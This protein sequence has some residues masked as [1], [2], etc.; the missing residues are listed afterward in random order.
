MT[1]NF[2]T[3]PVVDVHKENIKTI[4]PSLMLALK[5]ATYVAIDTELSGI[6]DR[7]MLNAKQI[8]D[9][10]KSMAESAKSRSI[11][12]MGLS[13]FKLIDVTPSEPVANGNVSQCTEEGDQPKSSPNKWTFSVQTF[14]IIALCQDEY[15]VEPPSLEFLVDHGFDF[16]KQY[17]KGIAYYRGPD[18]PDFTGPSFL[19]QLFTNLLVSEVPVVFH[20][21]LMDLLFLYQ[22]FYANLPSSSAMFLADITEMFPN[23]V[24]DTKYVTDFQHRMPASYLEYVFRRR[25]RDNFLGIENNK[26]YSALDIPSY[27]KMADQVIVCGV[28]LPQS[29]IADIPTEQIDRLKDSVCE[30]FS[31]HGWCGKGSNCKRSH[32][33]DLILD[34]D[35]LLQTKKRRKRKRRRHNQETSNPCEETGSTGTNEEVMQEEVTP[36]CEIEHES[37]GKDLALSPDLLNKPAEI[38]RSGSHRAGFDAFMTGFILST[39]ISQYGSYT[40]KLQLKDLGVDQMKNAI[41]LTAKDHPLM[42]VKSSFSKTS[43]EHKEKFMKLKVGRPMET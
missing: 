15:V 43:K 37:S 41:Y 23:G 13:C 38:V 5:S 31:G 33:I 30:V 34:M 7:K 19:R 17:S 29:Y 2:E 22:N 35:N 39:Y 1:A 9:R 20:N 28:K 3:V 42:I 32:D 11:V 16:N 18:R 27:S 36:E 12:S 8:E 14:N 40:G 6:G 4:W 21:A 24:I 25:Q 10:Y 26:S